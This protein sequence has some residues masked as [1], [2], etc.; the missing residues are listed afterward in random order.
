MAITLST[1]ASLSIAKTYGASI[2]VTAASNAAECVL[3]TASAHS[4]SVGDYV[5]VTSGW[6]RLDKRLARCKTGTTGSSIVLEGIDTS[7]T[8]KYPAGTGI[9]SVRKVSAWTALSQVKA[10]SASGGSQ[11][12]ASVTDISDV[13]ERQV[14]TT[15]SAVTMTI[16][17][18]DDPSLAWYSDVS[19]AD[20]ARTPYGLLMAF[21]NGSKTLANAY[22]SL[23]KIPTMA[24][25]EALMTQISLSYASEPTRYAS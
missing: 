17:C 24:Q 3:T 19:A 20:A 12:F 25:N 9:G 1:G 14:P 13:V 6:G 15:R 4:F 16:D 22:W 8:T 10:V 21:P 18:Y 2:N 5:E 11:N 23:M 7:D